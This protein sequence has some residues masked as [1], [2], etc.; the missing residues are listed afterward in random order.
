VRDAWVLLFPLSYAVH[1]L[2]EATA[3]ETFPRWFSRVAGADL[4]RSEFLAVNAVA[5]LVMIAAILVAVRA[6]RWRWLLASLGFVTAF[7]GMLHAAAS[8]ATRSYS[9][10]VLSGLVRWVPLGLATLRR[11][12]ATLTGRELALGLAGGIAVHALVSLVALSG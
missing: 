3:G 5:M 10:G 9:P 1:V 7:N 2:E 4:R 12:R 11:C 8:L 6:P